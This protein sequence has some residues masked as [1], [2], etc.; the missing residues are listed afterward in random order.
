MINIF[1]SQDSIAEILKNEKA[2]NIFSTI[3]NFI[4]TQNLEELNNYI[5]KNIDFLTSNKWINNIKKL[6]EKNWEQYYEILWSI[7]YISL[8]RKNYKLAEVFSQTNEITDK[9]IEKNKQLKQKTEEQEKQIQEKNNDIEIL[10]N[11][12]WVLTE[13]LKYLRP[14]AEKYSQILQI[15]IEN[16][17]LNKWNSEIKAL[18]E[19]IKWNKISQKLVNL[20]L[21]R[22]ILIRVNN[23]WIR[24]SPEA[25]IIMNTLRKA[26]KESLEKM[27]WK[28]EKQENTEETWTSKIIKSSDYHKIEE[29]QLPSFEKETN[30]TN[31]TKKELGELKELKEKLLEK[32]KELKKQTEE[33]KKLKELLEAKWTKTKKWKGKWKKKWQKDNWWN[34]IPEHIKRKAKKIYEE[35]K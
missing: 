24:I 16:W 26:E 35:E 29:Y 3:Q 30:K 31:S 34:T 17:L 18:E 1:N 8:K 15:L 20:L 4:K 21:E 23:W 25:K 7:F 6:I 33:I 10:T 27:D 22:W 28:A 14:V 12:N 2:S 32:D 11:E 19:I 5:T 13:E 9:L